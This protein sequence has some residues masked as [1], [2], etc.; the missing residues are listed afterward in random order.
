MIIPQQ[1]DPHDM[2]KPQTFPPPRRRC[3]TVQ[4]IAAGLALLALSGGALAQEDS[5][6]GT[7]KTLKGEARVISAGTATGAAIGG[8]VRQNDVIETGKDGA[9]GLTF[10]DNMTL[11]LGPNSRITL[12][13]LVFNPE[14]SDFAFL[15][16]FARGTMMVVS[17]GIAKL[18]P[19]SEAITTPVGTIGVRGT[20]FLVKVE[21][22]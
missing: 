3:G 19:Q 2:G 1:S 12:T 6:I 22:Q 7:I 18:A 17:G 15:A 11:S 20:R 16:D 8:A 5:R 21:E 13:K 14:K 4:T 10:I 9:L